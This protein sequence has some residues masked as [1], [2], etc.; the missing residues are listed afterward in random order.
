ML[1]SCRKVGNS[2]VATIP[3]EIIN[4]LNIMA[5]DELEVSA[6]GKSV[7]MT[8]IKKKLKGELFLEQFYQ[9]SIDEI[10][11]IETELADWGEPVGDEIW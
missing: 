10:G 11:Q 1:V 4:L 9:K 5:G 7:I 3:N 2:F 8:P 6:N